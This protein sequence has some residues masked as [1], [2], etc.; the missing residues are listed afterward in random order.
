MRYYLISGEPSGDLH[1]AY[2][3]RE[4]TSQDPEA[5]FRYIGGDL[6]SSVGGTLVQHYRELAYMGF[7]QVLLHS[8]TLLRAIRHCRQDII[9][10]APDRLIL[11]DYPGFNLRIAKYIRK[12]TAIRISYYIS[13]KLWAW[14]EGRIHTI[15]PTIYQMLCILPFDPQFYARHDYPATYV[16]NPTLDEISNF[17]A[18]YTESHEAFCQRHSLSPDKPI[19]AILAGSRRAELKDNLVRMIR[20]A[21]KVKDIQIVIAGAPSL[22]AADYIRY[23]DCKVIFGETYPLLLH[24]TAALVTSGTATLETAL[25]NCPQVVCYYIPFSPVVKVM[26]RL[27]LKV[28]YISLVNLIADA[29]L[30]PE[31]VAGDANPRRIHRELCAVMTHPQDFSVLHTRLGN[32]CAARRA[33]QLIISA[34]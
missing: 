17:R 9:D 24:S 30:V 12:H 20:A 25:L 29:E 10:Y 28:K 7:I 16:G 19:V 1:A 31:L 34:K 3:M 11:I 18:S 5:E 22:S 6:M 21:Q 8:R 27:F 32:N 26:R 14:K 2:L 13:P 33:A 15:C 23:T 4:L